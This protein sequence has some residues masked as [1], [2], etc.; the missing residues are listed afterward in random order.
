MYIELPLVRF[1]VR[2]NFATRNWC[3][4]IS[5]FDDAIF[6]K[7]REYLYIYT[8]IWYCV[9]DKS[10]NAMHSRICRDVCVCVSWNKCQVYFS[11]HSSRVRE[12][13]ERV[14]LWWFA[15]RNSI[16]FRV[17]IYYMYNT[18]L[19]FLIARTYFH[20]LTALDAPHTK[21]FSV[22][23]TRNAT[24]TERRTRTT[25][26]RSRYVPANGRRWTEQN[27]AVG[28]PDR[29]DVF[30]NGN[31]VRARRVYRTCERR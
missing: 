8:Y 30:V 16:C 5:Q 1:F 25:E 28:G 15:Q 27:G 24:R 26:R 6:T 22:K 10:V 20:T 23:D 13:H 12:T 14:R 4:A 17:N 31:L 29:K 2:P 19:L 11:P 7:L 18:L 3:N 9:R 21:R